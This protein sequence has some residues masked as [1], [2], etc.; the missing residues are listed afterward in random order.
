MK[1]DQQ[2]KSLAE[3]PPGDQ[4]T[5]LNIDGDD[6]VTARILEM[7]VSPGCPVKVI[8]KAPLGDPIEIEIR[9]YRLSIRIEEARRIQIS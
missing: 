9:N 5:I 3:L 1:Q 7:G 2:A 6:A 8:G 4:A